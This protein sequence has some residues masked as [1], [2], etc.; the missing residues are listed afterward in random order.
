MSKD[1]VSQ[2]RKPGPNDITDDIGNVV[3][4]NKK[5]AAPPDRAQQDMTPETVKPRLSPAPTRRG[6]P[7]FADGKGAGND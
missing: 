4:N 6:E 3:G 2:A 1:E 5:G 7:A